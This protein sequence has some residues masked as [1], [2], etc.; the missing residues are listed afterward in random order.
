MSK[1]T[2]LTGGGRSGKS[3]QALRLAE[4]FARKAFIATA[5]A[6]DDEMR[7][8]IARHKEERAEKFLTIEEPLDLAG[9]IRGLAGRADVVIVD[10]LTVWLGNLMHHRGAERSE[11]TEIDDLIDA[12]SAPPCD[13][14]LVTNEV[15]MGIIP[16]DAMT[17]R[18]R[19]LAGIIN[20][21]AAACANTVVLM[22]SGIPLTVKPR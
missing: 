13:V 16:I 7:A 20:Q 9:A 18:Y 2:L 10:C 11:Y 14:I 5:E 8:R 1:V 22:V 15:G 19:D 3:A 4:P 21:R 17:R 6:F 12:L